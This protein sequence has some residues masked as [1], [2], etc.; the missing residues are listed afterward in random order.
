MPEGIILKGI[1]GF[2]YVKTQQGVYECKARGIFRKENLTPLPGDRVLIAV[3]DEDKKVGNIS[4]IMQR[5]SD[6]IRPAVANVDQLAAVIAV[7]SPLPDFELL[8]KLLISASA[9]RINA[10]VCVNKIDLDENREYIKI[11]D[12]Y[13]KS[14]YKCIPLSSKINFGFEALREV[15]TGR[16]TVFS[17]QSGV[18]KSTIL[19][20]I[21]NSWV[22]QTGNIS[23]KIE[24]GRHTTRHAELVELENGGFI[25][26]TPGFSSI[27]LMDIKYDELELHYNEF[28]DYFGK[29]R[30]TGCSHISEPGCAVKDALSRGLVDSGRYERY[31]KFYNELKKKR[32]YNKRM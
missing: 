9:K 4:E 23:E 26:D 22:M 14:G 6:L 5:K 12:T 3:V 29:C 28:E 32:E 16:I 20:R 19:N 11:V 31:I 25:V 17:G 18:G 1:G 10:V 15:L 7:K 8:D 27:E 24:R 13:E 30:F 21:M 2:Y